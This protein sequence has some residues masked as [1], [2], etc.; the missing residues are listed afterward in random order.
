MIFIIIPDSVKWFK[1]MFYYKRWMEMLYFWYLWYETQRSELFYKQF[2]SIF[3]LLK[4]N[5]QK[6]QITFLFALTGSYQ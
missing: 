6:L 2:N 4:Q 5:W 1:F 3:G